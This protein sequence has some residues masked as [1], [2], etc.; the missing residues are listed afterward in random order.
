MGFISHLKPDAWCRWWWEWRKRQLCSCCIRC[1]L[2]IVMMWKLRFPH[3]QVTVN[4]LCFGRG[5]YSWGM[6]LACRCRAAE[7]I[8][9]LPLSADESYLWCT[10]V[11]SEH[12]KL[13]LCQKRS[14]PAYLLSSLFL[15][16]CHWNESICFQFPFNKW[17][18][19]TDRDITVTHQQ[20]LPR[21]S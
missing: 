8:C 15:S 10:A 11:N 17:G 21:G 19:C 18:K 20:S 16:V 4:G 1:A 14:S 5:L 3:L 9:S 12:A 7:C 2:C 13:Q 6:T